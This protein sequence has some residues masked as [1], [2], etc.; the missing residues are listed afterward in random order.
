MQSSIYK[1]ETSG[2]ELL[3]CQCTRCEGLV[4]VTLSSVAGKVSSG[5]WRVKKMTT[6]FSLQVDRE[7]LGE[8][9]R[10]ENSGLKGRH[11]VSNFW[12]SVVCPKLLLPLWVYIWS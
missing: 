2:K 10:W 9:S 4:S 6:P 12:S 8:K 5:P 3:S 7:K 1:C 11:D